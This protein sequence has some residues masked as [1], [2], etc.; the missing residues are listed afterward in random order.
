MGSCSSGNSGLHL[1]NKS[2][3]EQVT[4]I[5]TNTCV[6]FLMNMA[7]KSATDAYE[8]YIDTLKTNFRARYIARCSR[9]VKTEE[10][11]DTYLTNQYH[12]TLYYYN[13]S[14]NLVKT[15]P[16]EGIHP[17]TA[18]QVTAAEAYRNSLTGSSV[19]PA[20]TLLTIYKYNSL[21]QLV[22]QRTP[23][24]GTSYFF[25]DRLG[26]LV[27]SQNAKQAAASPRKYSYTIYDALGRV[28][29]VGEIQNA[30]FITSSI[31]KSS[32][33]FK[34]W[35]SGGT[36]SQITKT[37]YEQ[38]INSTVNAWFGSSGQENLRSRVASSIYSEN[39]SPSS[40]DYATHYSY[41][42]HGNVKTIIQENNDLAFINRA[43]KRIDYDFD[44]VSGKVN[45]VFY[46]KDSIDQFIHKYTYDGDNRIVDVSTSTDGV[47]WDKD[48]KY[49]Y[50][51]HGPLARVEIGNQKVQG[52]DYAYTLQGWIKGVNSDALDKSRDMGKDA[53]TSN[54]YIASQTGVHKNV[55]LDAMGYTLHYFDGDYQ[56]IASQTNNFTS[57]PISDLSLHGLYNGNIRASV[58]PMIDNNFQAQT[59]TGN[60]YAY[61]QLNRIANSTIY[62]STSTT[63]NAWASATTNGDYN[64]SYEYDANGNI[65]SLERN[66]LASVGTQKMDNLTYH[67]YTNSNKLEYVTEGSGTSTSAY[68][69]DIDGQS[70]GN[71]TYDQIGNLIHDTQEEIQDIKWNVYGKITQVIRTSTCQS[72]PDLEFFYDPQ[73]NRI[74]KIVKPRSAGNLLAQAYW[75]Y[76]FYVRDA[77]GNI[78]ATYS[79][80]NKGTINN[81]TLIEH[82]IYGSSRL[83]LKKP[84]MLIASNGVNSPNTPSNLRTIGIKQYELADWLGNVKTVITDKKLPFSTDNTTIAYFKPDILNST[85][86]YPFGMEMPG[87]SFIG[88]NYRYGFN[89]QEKDDEIKGSGNSY[90]F[91]FRIYD[92]RLGRFLSTDPLEMEYPWNS[93]Y[94]FAEN[95]P[96]DGI[97][98]EGKEWENI[99]TWGK[100]PGELKIKLPNEETAQRQSYR[101]S[102][103]NSKMSFDDFK[104]NF[105]NAPQDYLSNS[106]A[107]FNAPVDGEGKPSQFK[108]GSY[109]FIEI[110]KVFDDGYVVVKSLK[111]NKDGSLNVTFVTMEGHVE[112]GIINFTLSQ[113]KDGNTVFEINSKS[114]VDMGIAKKL[115]ET[116]ARDAQKE[117]W[118]EV[119]TN[120]VKILG[121]KEVSR[122]VKT[123]DPKPKSK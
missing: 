49:D 113:D 9:A 120:I 122:D 54:D 98:L 75:Q 23:D 38:P 32:Y 55:P 79:L 19:L 13:Q 34:G 101:V 3:I 89:G 41:D 72:K 123:E 33:N 95:R 82:S 61:D 28:A 65:L 30:V 48:A 109:I 24:A 70:A 84:N 27:V 46:Q 8:H 118:K 71:Y 64:T 117:S 17:L 107:K 106:K 31:T 115:F 100:K 40:Y 91:L 116:T 51:R 43:K 18:T 87:R 52:T 114:E 94:A 35:L 39:G 62:K 6:T 53:S 108:T 83:G 66:A 26:R 50:Y 12:Y 86:F 47:I 10:F 67:Y 80:Q 7:I 15:V 97:D 68:G 58:S 14:G 96:I 88:D 121:G 69:T 74:E 57:T 77:S 78:M 1:C 93:P 22:E 2:L 25:Y 5:D 102:V 45:K 11:T 90:D 44:L 63:S 105:K 76:T 112:K 37:Y 111:E 21:N 119:L 29:E 60:I 85:D 92:P 16:P 59:T 73:G 20:H 4:D 110:E 104:K 56:S 81:L 42:I 99:N 103:A 36:K